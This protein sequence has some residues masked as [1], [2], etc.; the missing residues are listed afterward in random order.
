MTITMRAAAEARA[1]KVRAAA[2]RPSQRRSAEELAAAPRVSVRLRQLKLRD[3][4]ADGGP[5]HFEG[6][7]SV[8]GQG[9]E[10]WDFFGPYTEQVSPGAFATT[11][12]QDGLDVPLVLQHNDLRRVARTTNGTLNLRE[13]TDGDTTGLWVEADLDPTDEDVRYIVPKLRSQL[14]DEMSFKFLI[15]AGQWSPDWMEYHIDSVDIHR[16]DVAIVGYGA[17]PL[18]AGAG[19]RTNDVDAVL[20]AMSDEQARAALSGLQAR[21]APTRTP[22][23]ITDEDVAHRRAI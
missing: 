23:L 9:Y 13:I 2:D 8:T 18:T 5:I 7:A 17:N 20:R 19:V 12:A 14:I 22:V 1:A 16:G 15:T 11:L 6:F 10:M 4:G 3:D 21:F